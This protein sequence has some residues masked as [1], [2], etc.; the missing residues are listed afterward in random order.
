MYSIAIIIGGTHKMSKVVLYETLDASTFKEYHFI[1]QINKNL[2]LDW[3]QYIIIVNG[4]KEEAGYYVKDKDVVL[5]RRIPLDADMFSDW[6]PWV[7]LFCGDLIGFAI[8]SGVYLNKKQQAAVDSAN[9]ASR[10]AKAKGEKVDQLPFIRGASN[11]TATGQSFPYIIGRTLFTPYKLGSS[12]YTISSGDGGHTQYYNICLETGFRYITVKALKIKDSV[13]WDSESVYTS[14]TPQNAI[15]TFNKDALY[16]NENNRLEV[17]SGGINSKFTRIEDFNKKLVMQ[18]VQREAPCA[19]ECFKTKDN[20][21]VNPSDKEKQEKGVIQDLPYFVHTVEV[22]LQF[23]GLRKYDS[24]WKEQSVEI[25]TCYKLNTYKGYTIKS[26]TETSDNRGV[27]VL[28]PDGWQKFTSD[29]DKGSYDGGRSVNGKGKV[30]EGGNSIFKGKEKKQLRFS[31]KEDFSVKTF[32]IVY[33][34]E[35]GEHTVTQKGMQDITA[36]VRIR[37]MSEKAETDNS[38]CSVLAIQTLCFDNK[39][40]TG[41]GLTYSYTPATLL[42]AR[43]EGLC[44]RVGVRIQADENTSESLEQLSLIVQGLARIVEGSKW[45]EDKR[46]TSNTAA[47]ALEVLTSD[48]QEASRYKDEEL[49]LDS[50][51]EWYNYC[52]EN[53][54]WANGAITK[55]EKKEN[56]LK[57][58]CENGDATLI[59]DDMTGL[60]KVV[61]DDGGKPVVALLNSDNIISSTVTKKFE[62][63]ADGKKVKYVNAKGGYDYD[64]FNIM[65][66][67]E[68]YDPMRHTLTNLTTTY[69][70]SYEQAYKLAWRQL[71]KD[72]AQRRSVSIKV[73]DE[74]FYY[75]LYSLVE[76]QHRTL[77]KGIANTKIVS[78]TL[79]NYSHGENSIKS[80]KTADKIRINASKKALFICN[81]DVG[82]VLRFWAEGEGGIDKDGFIYTDTFNEVYKEG[83]HESIWER[84]KDLILDCICSIGEAS[85]EGDKTATLMQI[86]GID[87]GKT[88]YTLSLVDYDERVYTGCGELPA[89]KTNLNCIPISNN[90]D[91]I[92]QSKMEEL[93]QN[94]EHILDNVNNAQFEANNELVTEAMQT[95]THGIH[96]VSV[97]KVPDVSETSFDDLIS[98]IDK[99]RRECLTSDELN[100][101]EVHI[102]ISNTDKT[103]NTKIDVT[104]EGIR[105]HISDISDANDEHFASIEKTARDFKSEYVENKTTTDGKIEAN[106][107]RITQTADS[108]KS[109]VQEKINL[110][111]LDNTEITVAS[112]IQQMADNITLE[113]GTETKNREKGDSDE[114]KARSDADADLRAGLQITNSSVL[115]YVKSGEKEGRMALSL[116]LPPMLTDS[117]LNSGI[118]QHLSSAEWNKVKAVYTQSDATYTENGEDRHYYTLSPT[119]SEAAIKEVW[120]ILKAHNLLGSQIELN[121]DNIHLTAG[122]IVMQTGGST[123]FQ[124]L[125]DVDTALDSKVAT[126]TIIDGGKIK[127]GLINANE[128]DV[129]RI[130][131]NTGD[132]STQAQSI[133]DSGGSYVISKNYEPFT[134][135]VIAGAKDLVLKPY[136]MINAND[137]TTIE[138]KS[139]SGGDTNGCFTTKCIYMNGWAPTNPRTLAGQYIINSADS[140][141]SGR[142]YGFSFEEATD[143]LSYTWTASTGAGYLVF[144][145]SNPNYHMGGGGRNT[146]SITL[147]GVSVSKIEVTPSYNLKKSPGI[148]TVTRTGG[149]GSYITSEGHAYFNSIDIAGA[150]NLYNANITDAQLTNAKIG[151]GMLNIV[152]SG[153]IIGNGS[154][155]KVWGD[156]SGNLF[157]TINTPGIERI[158]SGRYL[159]RFDSNKYPLLKIR[160]SGTNKYIDL[161]VS[162][163]VTHNSINF[164]SSGSYV[165]LPGATIPI[166]T[167]INTVAGGDY[168]YIDYSEVEGW[169]QL[170]SIVLAIVDPSGDSWQDLQADMYFSFTLQ[171]GSE[172]VV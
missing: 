58:L 140:S 42:E 14:R 112:K 172:C 154:S 45:T 31:C 5:I 130:I 59:Y 54:I 43:E 84:E 165:T 1:G 25:E 142:I 97:H 72:K 169:C 66:N 36:S 106:A 34:D 70:T 52:E 132:T 93:A 120:D 159:I 37:R 107:S 144:T 81:S 83:T 103:L 92:I 38:T 157:H 111:D 76:V 13:L 23:E 64:T 73:G 60:I 98:E 74:G 126:E 133:I 129:E 139:D 80:I 99:V 4:K 152:A 55:A 171:T 102:S 11:S 19:Y 114:A 41:E 28:T 146:Q 40:T 164:R 61:V 115:Q 162:P 7:M 15:Y 134:E 21:L 167:A 18:E 91:A 22:L 8:Y 161:Y 29:Y 121:A 138:S 3:T 149:K 137:I 147:N 128:L 153:Y 32:G 136:Q 117:R 87:A 158:G 168:K 131:L 50:F 24:S 68:E 62:V 63:K 135:T 35:D 10:T 47:W 48:I 166:N 85:D 53:E 69:I 170:H 108:I 123:I 17:V 33:E 156:L 127:T 89:Y 109:E 82:S 160:T 100:S 9:K 122:D 86:V 6:K 125:G 49:D 39:K 71:A 26:F 113:V 118:A 88:G 65:G 148:D 2:T 16:Y 57:A 163:S 119:A 75:P 116:E 104:A 155:I 105:E 51:L 101:E 12:F 90:R 56:I 143:G 67:G 145:M 46:E 150:A 77:S 78:I 44:A 27:E 79:T 30:G 141:K 110:G 20:N 124:K 151:N 96:Y 94:S 95:L